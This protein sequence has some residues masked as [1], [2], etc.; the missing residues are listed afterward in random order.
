VIRVL[1]AQRAPQ[2][3]LAELVKLDLQEIP[4]EPVIWAKPVHK[5]CAGP[6][7]H[8]AILEPQ[9]LRALLAASAPKV[10]EAIQVIRVPPAPQVLLVVLVPAVHGAIPV[11]L[12]HKEPR[13]Q[14]AP[15]VLKGLAV[16]LA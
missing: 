10:R 6:R 7:V 4:A 8:P 9:V 15:Q 14:R 3:L 12:A 2:G 1:R 16:Q 13:A 5:D 11:I